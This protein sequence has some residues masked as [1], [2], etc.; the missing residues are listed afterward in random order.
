MTA[1]SPS[2]AMEIDSLPLGNSM[3]CLG[4][5]TLPDLSHTLTV[6]LL[7]STT[8]ASESDTATVVPVF[9]WLWDAFITGV[10]VNAEV[11]RARGCSAVGDDSEGAWQAEAQRM[12]KPALIREPFFM[13]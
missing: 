3:S 1:V 12:H 5:H 4:S 13:S 9:G 10:I 6:L 8:M 7:V 11:V 2:R